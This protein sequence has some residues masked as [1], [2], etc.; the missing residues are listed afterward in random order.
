MS[1]QISDIVLLKDDDKNDLWEIVDIYNGYVNLKGKTNRNIIV[2]KEDSIEKPEEDLIRKKLLERSE[3]TSSIC[4][5]LKRDHDDTKDDSQEPTKVRIYEIPGSILHLDTDPDYLQ[6]CIKLY[7]E[8]NIICNGYTMHPSKMQTE[9]IGLLQKHNPDILV[10]TGH[11]GYDDSKNPNLIESYV[12]SKYYAQTVMKAREFEQDMDSLVIFAGACQSFFQALILAGANFASSP[13]RVNIGLFD[14]AI[15]ACNIALTPILTSVDIQRS[16]IETTASYDG[17]GGIQCEGRLKLATFSN[18]ENFIKDRVNLNDYNM[19]TLA[20]PYVNEFNTQVYPQTYYN[21][22]MFDQYQYEEEGINNRRI[23]IIIDPGHS[24]IM[25][26]KS[27]SYLPMDKEKEYETNFNI[28]LLLK[29]ELENYNFDTIIVKSKSNEYLNNMERAKIINESNG[30]L[31]IKLHC[32]RDKDINKNGALVLVSPNNKNLGQTIINEYCNL[33][34]INN[35]GIMEKRNLS[36]LNSFN[37]PT[38][39]LGMGYIS[40]PYENMI[41]TTESNQEEIAKSIAKGIVKYFNRN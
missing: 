21:S 9:V 17:I 28:S 36:S 25:N 18:T 15:I 39:I 4:R 7:K 31:V 22:Y 37:T 10:I 8:N 32:N 26:T 27:D 23:R 12:F 20:L 30:D 29:N 16:I 14:P 34:K 19:P 33:M 1:F 13:K 38:I 40:N 35:R 24:S 3:C 5:N 11:D 41:L 6:E 2:T